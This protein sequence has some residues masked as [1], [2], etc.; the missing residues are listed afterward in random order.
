MLLPNSAAPNWLVKSP[1]P[2]L[3]S[4]VPVLGAAVKS[5]LDPG[6]VGQG[7]FMNRKGRGGDGLVP[8]SWRPVGGGAGDELSPPLS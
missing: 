3:G 6:Q 1:A 5:G 8:G 2:I 7:Q 4:V